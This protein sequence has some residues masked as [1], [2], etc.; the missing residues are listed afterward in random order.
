MCLYINIYTHLDM[1]G[2][3]KEP[4]GNIYT[5]CKLFLLF[6][7]VAATTTALSFSLALL[8]LNGSRNHCSTATVVMYYVGRRRAYF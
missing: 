8:T 7:S 5:K 2:N 3:S 1:E 6:Y 4:V